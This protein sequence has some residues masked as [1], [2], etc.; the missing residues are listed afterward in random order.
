MT[1]YK[2]SADS[3]LSLLLIYFSYAGGEMSSRVAKVVE[4]C[5]QASNQMPNM[6]KGSTARSS[7]VSSPI[8]SV[9]LSNYV[10]ESDESGN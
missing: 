2:I 5:Q 6:A 1:T 8:T 9:S 4:L 10:C 7:V 3:F